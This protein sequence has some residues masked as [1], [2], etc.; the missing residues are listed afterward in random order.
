MRTATCGNPHLL[1][2]ARQEE[3]CKMIRAAA[4]LEAAHGRDTM[5]RGFL[6]LNA[7]LRET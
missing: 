5:P 6:G 2:K 3:V 7:A 4:E 1:T